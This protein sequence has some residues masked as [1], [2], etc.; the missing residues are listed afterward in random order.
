MDRREMR[1]WAEVSLDSFEHNY[2]SMRAR[3]PEGCR[4]LG[5]VKAN[6]YGHGAVK[7]A[8]RLEEA[9]ADYLAVAY[10]EEGVELREA[11]IKLPV[12][13]LG[14]TA[15]QY[16]RDVIE[17]GL[18]QAVTDLETAKEYSRAALD[19]DGPM[20]CHL[21]LDTGMGRLGFSAAR[22]V[23]LLAEA[24]SLPGLDVEGAFTHFAVSDMDRGSDEEYTRAQFGLFRSATAEAE[25][26][27]GKLLKI[28]HCTNSGAMIKYPWTYSDMVRPGIMLYG[29]YPCPETGGIDLRPCMCLKTRVVQVK[30]MKAGETV[31]YGRNWT[32]PRDCLV[33]VLSAGYADGLPR[34]ASGK[35][36]V[37]IRG[38]R[39]PLIGNICMDM[40]MADVTEIPDCAPGDE[41]TVFG[42]E[43]TGSLDALAAAAGTIT[44]ELLC[45]VSERV[46][47][48]YI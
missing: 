6:A 33:A 17:F 8:R 42:G 4:F 37:L 18:T 45:A 36:D 43:H 7:V 1:C 2:R 32:A 35:A 31:S 9:G 28:K 30:R 26:L 16:A 20:L 29:Y 38:K 22:D 40:V 25:R 5:V 10:I 23:E 3:L 47:R 48:V 39:A 19:S 44:Y 13:I 41:V 34:A 27:S 21:K 24:A 15:P 14:R 12:L 11:G 46:P